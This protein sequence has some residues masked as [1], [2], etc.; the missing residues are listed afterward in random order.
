MS[1][2]HKILSVSIVPHTHTFTLPTTSLREFDERCTYC[3]LNCSQM[4]R[5]FSNN[6]GYQD[7]SWRLQ[8]LSA[9]L[10]LFYISSAHTKARWKKYSKFAPL[11]FTNFIGMFEFHL[12]KPHTPCTSHLKN[13]RTHFAVARGETNHLQSERGKLHSSTDWAHNI[14]CATRACQKLWTI[15]LLASCTAGENNKF[16]SS[17]PHIGHVEGI[18]GGVDHWGI[19]ETPDKEATWY[20]A[21]FYQIIRDF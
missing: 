7:V 16:S 21:I 3:G 20:Q 9:D 15:S 6:S 11:H 19:F 1:Q 14:I 13:H 18:T 4:Q 8:L 10:E 17:F 2:P 5:Q 12:P